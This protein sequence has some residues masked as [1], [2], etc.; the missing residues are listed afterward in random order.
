MLLDILS[1]EL[2]DQKYNVLRA[3]TGEIALSVLQDSIGE[4][5]LLVTDIRLPGKVDGWAVAE[6][7]RRLRADLPV[8]YVTGYSGQVTREVQGS[9]LIAKPYRPSAIVAAATRLGVSPA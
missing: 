1:A 6:E 2:K 8:I 4:I 9:V 3:A 5:D 7:A